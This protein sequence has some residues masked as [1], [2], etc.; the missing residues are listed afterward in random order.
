MRRTREDIR[1]IYITLLHVIHQ[2]EREIIAEI[3]NKRELSHL[4]GSF[5]WFTANASKNACIIHY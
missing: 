4:K 1:L 5:I 3:E 2:N